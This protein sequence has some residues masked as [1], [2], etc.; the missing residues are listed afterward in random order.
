MNI[1]FTPLLALSVASA[2]Y[3]VIALWG[4]RRARGL[5]AF[6]VAYAAQAGA[7]TLPLHR[8]LWVAVTMAVLA[9]VYLVLAVT[10]AVRNR[11]QAA[12]TGEGGV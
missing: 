9:A 1:L 12:V 5:A 2:V 10:L 7:S 11:R 8:S 4:H 6:A 3:A